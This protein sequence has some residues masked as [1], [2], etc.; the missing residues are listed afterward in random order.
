MKKFALVLSGGGFKGAFQVGALEYLKENWIKINP[1]SNDMKFDIVAGVSVGSLNGLFV[2]S[3]KFDE[4]KDLWMNVAKNGVD[5]IYISDFIN[6][7]PDQDNPDPQLQL[8]LSLDTIKKRFP[9][10]TKNLLWRMLFSRAKLLAA[11]KEDFTNFKSIADNSPL[12]NKL[13]NYA[14]KAEIK[15][16]IYKCGYVSLNDGSYYSMKHTDFTT[17]LDFTNGILAST[18]MPII[19]GP[20]L[21][22]NTILNQQKYS[23]DG[24]IR[25]VSP[26]GDVIEEINND[27][28]VEEYLII[29]INCS[30]SE[31]EADNY[32]DKNIAQIALRSL[33]DIAITEIFNNDLEE[34]IDK[35][36]IL[37]QINKASPGTNIYDY[38]YK[39]KKQGKVMKRFKSIIIQPAGNVLGDT[40]LAN[41][42]LID[43]RIAHGRQKA[44]QALEQFTSNGSHFTFTIV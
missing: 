31:I 37:E 18:S 11:F 32:A 23:V 27:N 21:E 2:A 22:I 39:N 16:C 4:L 34:F 24:G 12:K 15:N 36:Y 17:D 30:S 40:L 38:D 13:I 1:D 9:N 8:K 26:L 5:E 6:T 3:N 19:W 44:Q 43:R 41:N 10:T 28:S 25:N 29:I 35:N 14:K 20:V 7:T 42:I 33:V